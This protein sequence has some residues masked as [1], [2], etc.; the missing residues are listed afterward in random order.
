M[1]NPII[2]IFVRH[3][4]KCKYAGDE[5]TKSCRCRKHLRWSKDG[6]Q[7]RKQAG[8][9]SWSEAEDAKRRFEDQLAG[10]VVKPQTQA[11][12]IRTAYDDFLLAKKVK[13]ITDDSYKKYEREILRFIAFCER[14]NVFTLEAIDLT[15][16]TAYKATWPEL[17]PSSATRAHVQQL[18]RVFL[19]YCH[20]AGWI[21]RVPKMD[22]VKIDQPPT[23][24]LSGKEYDRLLSAVPLEFTNGTAGRVRAIIQLMRWSGLSVRDASCLLRDDIIVHAKGK[25][26][27]R[28]ERQKTGVHVRVPIPQAVAEE[29]LEAANRGG[30]HLFHESAKGTEVSF[31][32]QYS[33]KI[34]SVFERAGIECEGHM[35]SHR[36]RDTFA[37]DLL[38][39]GVPMEEVSKMLGHESIT[40]TERHYAQWAKGRQDRVDELVT[41]TWRS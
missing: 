10:R 24:P 31:S 28:T 17:F 37:V 20:A 35:V 34:S 25:Y 39:K 30:A 22:T 19:N 1:S 6:K 40:T 33:R 2:T 36:L 13:E 23:M 4:E 5:F 38:T 14:R 11:R 18:L 32:Q 12:T 29:I 26:H 15:L 21:T 8:T 3:K 7:Y 41:A 9:R 27:V 16:V